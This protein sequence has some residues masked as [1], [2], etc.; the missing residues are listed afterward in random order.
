VGYEWDD[1]DAPLQVVRPIDPATRAWLMEQAWA[2]AFE[3]HGVVEAA[4]RHY[5]RASDRA[6]WSREL[7]EAV[8]RRDA[9]D[10][11]AH[12]TR[13]LRHGRTP[14]RGSLALVGGEGGSTEATLDVVLLE[15]FGR[16]SRVPNGTRFVARAIHDQ[17][18]IVVVHDDLAE[19][20][21]VA[22]A[23]LIRACAPHT[24][25][26]VITEDAEVADAAERAGLTTCSSSITAEDLEKLL[27]RLAV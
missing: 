18:D 20:E 26:L 24:M 10:V 23:L 16:V 19:L 7:L 5:E 8:D 12:I 6:A 2:A 3:D 11:K 15:H 9:S 22:V 13:F 14:E 17:P 25:L 1:L 21:P 27:G 4:R